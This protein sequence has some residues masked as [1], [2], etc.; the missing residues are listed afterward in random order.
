MSGSLG[1]V[2]F[3]PLF[4]QPFL[5]LSNLRC[6]FLLFHIPSPLQTTFKLL[7]RPECILSFS[8]MTA[9]RSSR[10]SGQSL[11]NGSAKSSKTA[12]PLK[13]LEVDSDHAMAPPKPN[14]SAKRK[15][16]QESRPSTPKRRNKASEAANLS[17]L[18]PKSSTVKVISEESVVTPKKSKK[19]RRADPHAT[20]APLQTPG[21]SRVVK[22]YEVDQLE[23]LTPR[24][25]AKDN[26]ITTDNLLDKACEHLCA[27]DSRL[28]P[29]VK[30]HTCQIFTPEGLAEEVDPFVALSSSIIS[31]QVYETQSSTICTPESGPN[32]ST[33]SL[34]PPLHLLSGSSLVYFHL[35]RKAR[36]KNT[37]L[38]QLRLQRLRLSF[39]ELQD[40]HNVKPSTLKA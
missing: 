21:G 4:A 33:R 34:V 11:V 23:N 31:Q 29:L 25:I 22:T 17:D 9:R 13:S 37:F 28:H 19:I 12:E 20:N 15:V 14:I 26:I 39:S 24:K 30:R 16:S 8:N 5:M 7:S 32:Y 18:T 10:L 6:I 36:L 1:R 40:S 38:L 2:A 3:L 35:H 27:V